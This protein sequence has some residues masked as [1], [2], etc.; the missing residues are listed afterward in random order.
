MREHV[1][2]ETRACLVV[3]GRLA[4]YVGAEPGVIDEARLTI[5]AGRLLLAAGG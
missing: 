3:G 5:Q 2:S 4:G 1:A